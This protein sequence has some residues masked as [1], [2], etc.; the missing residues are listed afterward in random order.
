MKQVFIVIIA[1]ILLATGIV[2][3]IQSTPATE[4]S[5]DVPSLSENEVC[6]I[7]YNYLQSRVDTMTS[8]F[9]RVSIQNALPKARPHFNA[10]YIGNGQWSVNAL[11][12]GYDSDEEQWYFYYTGGK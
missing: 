4:T 11:G 12:Y 6:A 7:V 8:S 9:R 3:C 2:S 10:V 1:I 5:T